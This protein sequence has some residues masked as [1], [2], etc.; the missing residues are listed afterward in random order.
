MRRLDMEHGP[1]AVRREFEGWDKVPRSWVRMAMAGCEK[2]SEWKTDRA[3][4]AAMHRAY[5]KRR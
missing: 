4:L 1:A 3:R 5:R 2:C